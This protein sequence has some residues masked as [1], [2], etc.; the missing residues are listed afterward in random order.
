MEDLLKKLIKN[1]EEGSYPFHMPGHKRRTSKLPKELPYG[2]DITEIDGFDDLHHAEGI[3]RSYMEH[4]ADVF[5]CDRLWYLVN[6]S[7]AGNLAAISAVAEYGD[8]IIVARNCHKSVYNAIFLRGLKP[9][10]IYPDEVEEFGI[11]GAMRPYEVE[12]ALMEHP[13]AKAV[14]LTSPTYEGIV[15]NVEKIAAICH[16]KNVPLLIDEA[17]GAHFGFHP[18]FPDSAIHLGADLVINSVHK[19][20]PSLTQTAILKYKAHG[21]L[22]DLKQ[23]ERYLSIYQSSSPSYILMASIDCCVH[24][25]EKGCGLFDPY[26]DK[27]MHFYNAIGKELHCLKIMDRRETGSWDLS[28]VVIMAPDL[29]V[30]GETLSEIFRADYHL[31][32]EMAG[33]VYTLAMTSYLDEEEGID[34]LEEALLDLDRRLAEDAQAVLAPYERKEERLDESWID[35]LA[36]TVSDEFVYVYPPGIPVLAPGERCT[37]EIV[38]QLHQYVKDGL[39]IHRK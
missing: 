14:F 16:K 9:V 5:G 36:G 23:V 25:V 1:R 12:T 31:E 29:C 21:G 24:M 38:K 4:A 28:K 15:S 10:W 35:A 30:D 13:D 8:T 18:A 37:E 33:P 34:R 7:T 20:L 26:V 17:H 3:L 27:M 39:A 22:I 2:F 6:G 32:M 11:H 19:T